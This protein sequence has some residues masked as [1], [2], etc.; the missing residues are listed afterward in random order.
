MAQTTPPP[1]RDVFA[2]GIGAEDSRGK[3][4]F[5]VPR[6]G[7][8]CKTWYKV[9]GDISDR[10]ITPTIV[11]HGGPGLSHWSVEPIA[12]GIAEQYSLPTVVYDQVGCG[13]STHLPERNGDVSF[14]TIQ[15]FIDELHNLLHNLG[16]HDSGYNLVG[17]SWGGMLA[18]SFAIQKPK[19]LK[20]LVL[21]SATANVTLFA[22]GVQ[23]L[24]AALPQDVQETLSKHEEAG[25]VDSKEYMSA[26]TEF[27]AR[28]ICR[29]S[30]Q[31]DSEA[32]AM[33]SV[34]AD[35]TV[36]FTMKGKTHLD[37]TGS[38]KTFDLTA[39]L[40][41]IEVPTLVT[42][43]RHDVA[44]DISVYPFFEHIRQ[45]KWVQFADSSHVAHLEEPDRF[46]D[47]VTRFL[48][49]GS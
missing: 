49:G 19:G 29:I 13:S 35:P 47:V 18:A 33:Q 28:H 32:K 26:V 25:T 24:R 36:Y 2:K 10:S 1:D 14:W 11:L 39:E 16:V 42:N 30:P 22:K 8:P 37:T 6:A 15:L 46:L 34:F 45:V 20:R 38:L 9:Y 4:N 5:D 48:K 43:G 17:H 41:N 7:K 44:Q 3:V 12:A 31:P 40:G 21:H 23:E 27:G